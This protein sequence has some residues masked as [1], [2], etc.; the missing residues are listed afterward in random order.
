MQGREPYVLAEIA[1]QPDCWLRALQ[2]Q[3]EAAELLPVA[4]AGGHHRL[5][6]LLARRP[7]AAA[8]RE[9]AGHGQT[10]AFPA[11]EFPARAYDS[12]LA[13]TRSGTTSEVL[14]ALQTM[15]AAIRK[16]GDHRRCVRA[17]PRCC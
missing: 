16:I 9:A 13:I 12:V 17:G 7:A 4:G 2:S 5:R 15:P 14:H 6:H 8:A 3:A 1:S 10:D 11:S